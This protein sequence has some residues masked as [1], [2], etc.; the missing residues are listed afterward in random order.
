[1]RILFMIFL[2][3]SSPLFAA[4]GDALVGTWKL[5]SWQVIVENEPPQNVFGEHPKGFLVLTRDGRSIVLTTAENR[6]RGMGDAERAALHK[7]M[8]A[9]SGR[10]RVEGHDF[11]TVVDVSWNEEWNGTEQRRHFRI[12]DDKLYID[13]A[14]APSI[15]FPGK[16]DFRRIVWQREK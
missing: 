4:D 13:S 3:I 5:V 11:I 12:E 6:R 14:P 2:A 1:M 15:L 8:L 16:T 10:Y 9:Y 7:S